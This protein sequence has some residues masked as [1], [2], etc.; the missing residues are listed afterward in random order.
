MTSDRSWP[1]IR[2]NMARASSSS[3]RSVWPEAAGSGAGAAPSTRWTTGVAVNVGIAAAAPGAGLVWTVGPANALAGAAAS[4][5]APDV[6]ARGRD[7]AADAPAVAGWA[8][9]P[10]RASWRVGCDAAVFE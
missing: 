6:A 7:P 2:P 8:P 9:A 5:L 4:I 10:A 3:S 1:R